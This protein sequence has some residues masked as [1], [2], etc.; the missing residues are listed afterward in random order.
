M[1]CTNI[2]A[3][4]FVN[5]VPLPIVDERLSSSATFRTLVLITLLAYGKPAQPFL[6]FAMSYRTDFPQER[7]VASGQRV[8]LPELADLRLHAVSMQRGYARNAFM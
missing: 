1:S 5:A 7:M 2:E 8:K 6:D 4:P 3:F